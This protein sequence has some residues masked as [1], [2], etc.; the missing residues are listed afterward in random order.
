[1]V[2][3]RC[4]RSPDSAF[5]CCSDPKSWARPEAALAVTSA[6]GSGPR[7]AARPRRSIALPASQPG[8]GPA[9]GGPLARRSP[10]APPPT[11]PFRRA[12]QAEALLPERG[13][14]DVAPGRKKHVGLRDLRRYLPAGVGGSGALP[15]PGNRRLGLGG[16]NSRPSLCFSRIHVALHAV[17]RRGRARGEGSR[18]R[19]RSRSARGS[20]RA[21][22]ASRARAGSAG[23]LG[24]RAAGRPLRRREVRRARPPGFLEAFPPGPVSLLPELPRLCYS[25]REKDFWVAF[26]Q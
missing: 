13:I 21:S 6:L 2:L 7:L 17:G 12:G 22:D 19:S 18:S 1:M 16:S 10:R 5:P 25:L 3:L 26:W 15:L 24:E 11:H 9:P 20:S 14:R 8:P 4:F 23:R